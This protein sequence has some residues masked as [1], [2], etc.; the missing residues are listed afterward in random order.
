MAKETIKAEEFHLEKEILTAEEFEKLLEN[1]METAKE[2]LISLVGKLNN[3][4]LKTLYEAMKEHSSDLT[5][6]TN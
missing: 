2:Y 1:D 4:D 5:T 3:E 6:E